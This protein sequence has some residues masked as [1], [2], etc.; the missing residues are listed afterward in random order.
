M[1]W[2]SNSNGSSSHGQDSANPTMQNRV[3]ATANGKIARLRKKPL[4]I[5]ASENYVGGV[6]ENGATTAPTSSKNE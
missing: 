3:S 6:A 2:R 5:G 1:R 4:M